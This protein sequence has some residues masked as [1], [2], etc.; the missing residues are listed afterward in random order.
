MVHCDSIEFTMTLLPKI[1]YCICCISIKY[2]SIL[3]GILGLSSSLI[4]LV[5]EFT[6]LKE[7]EYNASPEIITYSSAAIIGVVAYIILLIGIVTKNLKL[8]SI[9]LL[10][11]IILISFRST[12][13]IYDFI[14]RVMPRLH[15]PSRMF[16]PGLSY[17]LIII[18]QMYLWMTVFSYQKNLLN[19]TVVV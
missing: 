12:W 16:M 15:S 1:R 4:I 9:Y 3:I 11:E 17:T 14:T 19:R 2:G 8:I 7:R 13:L 10:A 18:F 5:L 6:H